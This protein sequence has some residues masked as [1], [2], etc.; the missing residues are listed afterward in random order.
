[1]YSRS[2][3][4]LAAVPWID[5]EEPQT[6]WVLGCLPAA[7]PNTHANKK[8]FFNQSLSFTAFDLTAAMVCWMTVFNDTKNSHVRVWRS[9]VT[10]GNVNS[11]PL[12]ADV[13]MS[14]EDSGRVHVP[15]TFLLHKD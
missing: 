1:M 13:T 14:V 5:V 6:L 2:N 12:F 8:L 15:A 7:S 4:S 10:Q 11:S 3:E 9:C